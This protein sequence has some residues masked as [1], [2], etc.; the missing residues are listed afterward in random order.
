ML[1]Q[2]CEYFVRVLI[3]YEPEIELYP[4]LCR[5]DRLGALADIAGDDAANGT[6]RLEDQLFLERNS[7]QVQQEGLQ[8]QLFQRVFLVVNHLLQHELVVIAQTRN[9]VIKAFD[10]DT[11]IRSLQRVQGP[12]Q[13]PGGVFDYRRIGG[14]QVGVGSPAN[15][16]HI[17]HPF[18]PEADLRPS[19][20]VFIAKLPDATVGS[21]PVRVLF[22]EFLQMHAADL[23]LA[24]DDELDSYRQLAPYLEASVDGSQAGHQIALVVRHSPRIHVPIPDFRAKRR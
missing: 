11:L 5:Q 21:D 9:L 8:P 17:A 12:E 4:R 18:Y 1:A 22:H 6:S 20:S 16:L 2:K 23:F 14:V 3:G 24:L 13:A 15:Q 19:V 7:F 10:A